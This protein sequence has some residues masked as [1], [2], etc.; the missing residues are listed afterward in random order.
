MNETKKPG[1]FAKYITAGPD[2][3]QAIEFKV[4]KHDGRHGGWTVFCIGQDG[5]CYHTNRWI[6]TKREAVA[7]VEARL[8]GREYTVTKTEVGT[9][10]IVS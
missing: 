8:T 6:N 7:W 4:Q 3:S 2:H 10:Y 9:S 1:R 5:Q